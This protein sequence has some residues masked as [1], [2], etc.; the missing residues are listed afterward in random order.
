MEEQYSHSYRILCRSCL[1]PTDWCYCKNIQP[2]DVGMRFAI[3]QHPLERRRR[4]AT[5]RMAYLSVQGSYMIHG[6]DFNDDPHIHALLQ[7]PLYQPVV[8]YPEPPSFN[9][10]VLSLHE[11]RQLI[12][13]GKKLLIFV[14]DGT[15]AT[16]KKTILRSQNLCQLPRI[17]FQ[18]RQ[19]SRFR[20]RKQPTKD[21]FSTIEAVHQCIDLLGEACGFDLQDR[22]HDALLTTFDHFVEA[23]VQHK[24]ML[25]KTGMGLSPRRV[26]KKHI[27]GEK[28]CSN[29]MKK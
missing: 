3:L 26:E 22:R 15:W 14:I 2:L 12:L 13:D 21:C 11:K 29:K 1:Q 8:L 17:F 28:V 7:N 19:Q 16:A 20:I 27:E 6:Y 23:H 18:P 24:E 10:D 25:K 4:I 5:G 9:L